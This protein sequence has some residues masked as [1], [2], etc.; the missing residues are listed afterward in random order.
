MAKKGR[1]RKLNEADI[2]A[3]M[4]KMLK[5]GDF[6][7]SACKSAGISEATYYRWREEDDEFRDST[8]R[9]MATAKSRCLRTVKQCM[10]ERDPLHANATRMKAAQFMLKFAHQWQFQKSE[11]PQDDGNKP[12]EERVKEAKERVRAGVGGGNEPQ[13]DQ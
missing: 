13:G 10:N 2:K 11:Q 1:P 9:A 3:S 12:S 7:E 6:P 4:V 8:T 5:A